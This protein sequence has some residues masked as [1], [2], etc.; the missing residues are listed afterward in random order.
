MSQIFY[1]MKPIMY[2]RVIAYTI[3]K[4]EEHA[5]VSALKQKSTVTDTGKDILIQTVSL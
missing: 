3:N 2:A 4:V 1:N 5:S